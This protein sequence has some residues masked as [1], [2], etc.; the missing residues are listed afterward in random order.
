MAI[1]LLCTCVPGGGYSGAKLKPQKVEANR[2][3]AG[4]EWDPLGQDL[5]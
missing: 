1:L 5:M 2:N 4:G 3:E